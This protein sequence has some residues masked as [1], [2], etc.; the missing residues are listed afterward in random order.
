MLSVVPCVVLKRIR[1][2]LPHTTQLPLT[3]TLFVSQA[4]KFRSLFAFIH[5]S[6]GTRNATVRNR[7]RV[8]T[9]DG[10]HSGAMASTA[11]AKVAGLSSGSHCQFLLKKQRKGPEGG[12][13]YWAGRDLRMS[14]TYWGVN[15]CALLGNP[16]GVDRS[17]AVSEARAC[18]CP[19]GGYAGRPGNDPH[20]LHTLSAVQVLALCGAEL[21]ATEAGTTASWIAGLQRADGGFDGDQFG[22]FDT[23][24]SYAALATLGLL[25][26]L[27]SLPAYGSRAAH[28]CLICV[29]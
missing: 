4:P 1:H 13:E 15:A 3:L 19:Q 2:L 29:R 14:G 18:R 22:G 9:D 8:P 11:G 21:D 24:Y 23:R 26:R 27:V 25:G 28:G 10:P 5:T 7:R 16:D 17:V 6:V 20:I 12:I